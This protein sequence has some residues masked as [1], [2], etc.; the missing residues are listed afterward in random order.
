MVK[1]E[2]PD[3]VIF[4]KATNVDL[5]V[6]KTC[7][8]MTAL[9]YWFPDP[10]VTYNTMTAEFIEKTKNCDYFCCDKEN[11][12]Q[13]AKKYNPHGFLVPDGF[14]SDLEFPKDLEE[15]IDVSFI[16]NLY[17]ERR[18]KIEQVTAGV[19]VISNAFGEK[20][21]EIASRSKINLN[22]CTTAGA[23]DRI[24]KLLGAKGFVLSDDWEGREKTFQDG[25]HLVI[26]EDIDDLN[27]KIDYYL[28]HPEERQ[29]ISTA[30]H[31]EVQK[32]TR[33]QWAVRVVK[34]YEEQR[35]KKA[36]QVQK[37][38]VLI[39]GP[40]IGE[41]GWELFAW[42]AYIRELSQHYDETVCIA[43]PT[44][45]YLY[46]DF[47]TRFIGYTATGGLADSF[48]MHDHKLN[49]DTF[50]AIFKEYNGWNITWAAPKRV[51]NPPYTH[52]TEPQPFSKH[53]I[54]PNYVKF[55][56]KLGEESSKTVIIHARARELRKD[57]NWSVDNWSELVGLLLADSY[58]VVSIGTTAQA[59]HIEGTKDCR[60]I[61]LEETVALLSN[62]CAAIGP[63]SGPMHLASLCGCPHLV[64]SKKSDVQR[65]EKNWNPHNTPVLFLGEYEWRP[66]PQYVYENFKKWDF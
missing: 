37:P 2:K 24:Y 28:E 26:F 15:D 16:G 35:E 34:H 4:A 20:H 5:K 23:S 8:S 59:F 32:Y 40:W 31:Q 44:S 14:D 39:A 42:Q 22:F 19:E 65:Y 30:G 25:E 45:E 60:D 52:F 66:T 47:A 38:K 58:S 61:P 43:R 51:G 55:Q 27:A 33:D 62:A 7:R 11:V 18:R 56:E 17:G 54:V 36:F 49:R 63:S 10:L 1:E 29:R 9:C 64:W 6:F 53:M 50:Q 3:L 13:E 41:F 21:S 48:F 12:L 57:D 46:K